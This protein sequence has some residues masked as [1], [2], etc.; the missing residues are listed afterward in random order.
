MFEQNFL[1]DLCG[2]VDLADLMEH[3]GV[4]VRRGSG[5]NHYYVAD[6]CCGKSDFDNGRITKSTQL[7]HCKACNHGGNAINFLRSHQA[8]SFHEAVEWL[9]DYTQ[10]PLPDAD[11][12]IHKKEERRQEALRLAAN[13]YASFDH[14]YLIDRGISE[15]VLKAVKAGYAP[16][17]RKL[18]EYLESKGFTKEELIEYELINQKG[19]DSFFYRAIIPIYH[20]RKVVS[21]YGRAVN[22]E[23]AFTKHFY[24]PAYN[25][26]YGIDRI[27]PEKLVVLHESIIDLLVGESHG[28]NNGVSP[29]GA[30]K[31]TKYHVGLLVKKGVKRVA[32]MYDGD[33]AGKQGALNAGELLTE[34]GIDVHI[35]ELPEKE[36]TASLIASGGL[37]AIKP[38][39]EQAKPFEV[40]KVY[41]ILR[42]I[43]IET[44]EEFLKNEVA[45]GRE[46]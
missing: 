20:N 4:K 39:T 37:E 9:C 26:L 43:P 6:W 7:Y 16:G 21:L 15:P 32:I 23:K 31:F 24:S 46:S 12:E 44:I 29:G 3:F 34:A 28:L 11:P 40:F 10:T 22:D 35:V 19:L 13:F 5:R 27:D 14:T 1:K 45:A 2:Q 38:Y 8:M 36:D 25:F 17:G 30:G 42:G 41:Q 18:R 33:Q